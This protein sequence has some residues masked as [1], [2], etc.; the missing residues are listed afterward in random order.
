VRGRV[1]PALAWGGAA[2]VLRPL[3][4]F[5]AGTPAGLALADRFR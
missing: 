3:L 2:L 5:V 4:L 1:H